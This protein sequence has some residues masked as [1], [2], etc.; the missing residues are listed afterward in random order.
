M[1]ARVARLEAT[2]LHKTSIALSL[3]S[4]ASLDEYKPLRNL[5]REIQHG[6]TRDNREENFQQKNWPATPPR[7][8]GLLTHD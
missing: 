1:T 2:T 8:A 4:A 7:A 3:S 5:Y 6:Q